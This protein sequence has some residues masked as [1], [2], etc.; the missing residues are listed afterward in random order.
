MCLSSRLCQLL[1]LGGIEN[2]MP[3]SFINICICSRGSLVEMVGD[4]DV[5]TF[6]WLLNVHFKFT[7]HECSL[8]IGTTQRNVTSYTLCKVLIVCVAQH[9]VLALGITY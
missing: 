5:A 4:Y 2:K 8:G 1:L 6:V 9:I 7:F 3:L